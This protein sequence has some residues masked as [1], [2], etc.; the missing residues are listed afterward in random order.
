MLEAIGAGSRERIGPTDWAELW[1]QSENFARVKREIAEIKED[2]TRQPAMRD[3]NANKKYATPFIHQLR[4]VSRRALAASWRQPEYGFTRLFNHGVI[5]LATSLTFL[6][7]GNSAQEIQYRVFAIFMAIMIPL[8]IV[9]EVEPMFI[10]ARMT[11]IRE[12]SSRMYSEF[13]FA[14]GQVIA[15]IPYSLLCAVVYF[16]LFSYPSGFQFA[17]D[18]A[19]YQF[20]MIL[21]I[22]LFSVTLA[23]MIASFSPTI[24]IAGL[25]NPFVLVTLHTF[26]GVMVP[27]YSIPKFWRS[28]LYE[29]NPFTR[30]VSGMVST[31]LHGLKITC[32]PLE[33]AVFQPPQGQTC[34]QWAGDFVNASV[35]YLDNPDGTSDC[36]YCPYEYGD[37]FYDG[38]GISFDNRW[39]DLGIVIGFVICNVVLT[40]IA[41]RVFKFSKR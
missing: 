31:E 9:S 23:Q 39:R 8:A 35:G 14:L 27:K 17:P 7:L 19:G 22:E 34:L 28:W 33:F 25:F 11:F 29:L 13:V 40:L 30:V 24:L 6:Q 12:S 36:R 41:S 15:E 4:V 20:F 1:R 37:D 32:S 2:V 3:P 26:C 5:A 10:H 38:F 21:G 16:V 18:R